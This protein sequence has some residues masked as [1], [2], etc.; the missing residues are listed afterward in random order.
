MPTVCSESCVGRIRYNGIMLYD[1]DKIEALASTPNEQDLYQAQLD[2]FLDPNDPEVIKQA[3][4]D[5]VPEDWISAAQ[6]SPIYKMAVDWKIAFP[7]HPEFRTLP[8]VWYVPPL[9]PVQSHI[10]QGALSSDPGSVIPP[11]ENLRMPL[12]YLANLLTAGKEAPIVSALKRM[13]AMRAYQ[14]S[15]H[16]EGTPDT[17]ALDEIG[18]S[19]DMALEMYR[20]LAIANYED[21]FV[22]PTGHQEVTLEDFYGHQGQNG[23]TF[24]ND[25]SPGISPNSLFPERRK[26]TVEPRDPAPAAGER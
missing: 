9:S 20:Y 7:M 23:F 10:D 17:R 12:K 16:V 8:M 25:S 24:G 11:V 1:A 19:V 26:E 15:V 22:I 6:K 2:I 5:G 13:I 3:R 21:R 4:I 14:R 18:M